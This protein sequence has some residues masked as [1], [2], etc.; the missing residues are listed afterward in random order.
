VEIIQDTHVRTNLPIIQ[1]E[2]IIIH[3][4]GMDE[5]VVVIHILLDVV[6]IYMKAQMVRVVL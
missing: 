2:V 3:Q 5:I 4:M 1:V 6:Q